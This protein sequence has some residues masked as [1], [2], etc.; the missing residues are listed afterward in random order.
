MSYEHHDRFWHIL[1]KCPTQPRASRNALNMKSARACRADVRPHRHARRPPS[2]FRKEGGALFPDHT[3]YL[4]AETRPLFPAFRLV[5]AFGVVP[6]RPKRTTDETTTTTT[7]RERKKTSHA[8]ARVGPPA[9]RVG[10]GH[11]GAVALV[12]GRVAFVS[13]VAPRGAGANLNDSDAAA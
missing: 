4:G 5:G 11:G 12:V 7:R 8:T 6:G 3:F 9:Q 10:G 1:I 13:C 2:T